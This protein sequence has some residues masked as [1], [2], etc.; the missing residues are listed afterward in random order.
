MQ[1]VHSLKSKTPVTQGVGT[2]IELDKVNPPLIC[3]LQKVDARDSKSQ[4]WITKREVA[5]SKA[6]YYAA[7]VNDTPINTLITISGTT[8]KLP[9]G[10]EHGFREMVR[11]WLTYRKL[12]YVAIWARENGRVYGEHLHFA[13]HLPKE[14]RNDFRWKQ[15]HPWLARIGQPHLKGAVKLSPYMFQISHPELSTINLINYLLKG[16]EDDAAFTYNL[17]ANHGKAGEVIGKRIGHSRFIMNVAHRIAVEGARKPLEKQP[18]KQTYKTLCQEDTAL[19]QLKNAS[20]IDNIE[21]KK[22]RKV[23]PFNPFRPDV[24]VSRSHRAM[25]NIYEDGIR[26]NAMAM[27][28]YTER[29]LGRQLSQREAVDLLNTAHGMSPRGGL[30]RRGT[31][32]KARKDFAAIFQMSLN[33]NPTGFPN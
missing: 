28:A 21:V 13:F 8:A 9:Q 3:S 33:N 10:W 23:W 31:Y 5:Q 6:C 22:Y 24:P 16:C 27:I 11:K 18:D 29:M 19:W 2:S 1:N 25:K 20:F 32:K 17:E 30:W 14:L 7:L 15:V 4:G 12:P 26:M